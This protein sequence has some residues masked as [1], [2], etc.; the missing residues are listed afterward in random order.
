MS[1]TIRV[2]LADDHPTLRLGLRVLLDQAPDV[3]VVGEA[4]NGEEAL[5]LIGALVP[6]VAV[7][8]CQLPGIIEGSQ[9]ALE[10][11]RRGLPVRVLALSAYDD[12]HY[13]RGMLE[14]GA[15]GYLLK[16]EAPE[17]IVAA[18]RTAARGERL[19]TMEQFARARRWREEVEERWSALT[20]REREVL[21][22]VAAGESN[23]EIAQALNV[24]VR[25]VEF[26]VS[27]VLGK[28]GLT[29]RVEA[30]VWAKEHGLCN[31]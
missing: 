19:W 7:L 23:K 21:A 9:V 3:E 6:D 30:A 11:R 20:E 28:L 24:T 16:D 15:A 13:V 31:G 25:T 5:A 1:K 12:E 2:L 8:D 14:A 29:S 26:H 18:V 17:V 4:E 27:N 22:L 10:I